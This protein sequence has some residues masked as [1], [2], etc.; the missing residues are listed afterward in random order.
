MGET[1]AIRATIRNFLLSQFL[2][3]QG[4]GALRDD[5]SLERS[6]IVDSARMLEIMEFLEATFGFTVE[7]DDAIPDNFDTVNNIVGYVERKKASS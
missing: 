7:P 5:Q 4:E 3:G 6:H 1:T 2:E